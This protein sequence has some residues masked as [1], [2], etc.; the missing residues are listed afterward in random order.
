MVKK[1]KNIRFW[2]EKT[3][4]NIVIPASCNKTVVYKV[5]SPFKYKMDWILNL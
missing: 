4:Q 2:D 3:Y 1:H 5:F